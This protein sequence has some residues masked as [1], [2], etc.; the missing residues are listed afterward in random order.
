MWLLCQFSKYF[1]FIARRLPINFKWMGSLFSG[2]YTKRK[3][4]EIVM[5]DALPYIPCGRAG[6]VPALRLNSGIC[7]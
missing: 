6:Q 1:L 2:L 3:M 4:D 5:N 7:V